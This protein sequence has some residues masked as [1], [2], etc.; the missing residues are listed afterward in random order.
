MTLKEADR[1]KFWKRAESLATAGPALQ[2]K[3][4]KA[5]WCRPEFSVRVRYLKGSG[6]LRHAALAGLV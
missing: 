1:E 6:L 2:L 5:S 3:N 4:S